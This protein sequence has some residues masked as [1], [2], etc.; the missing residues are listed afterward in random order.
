MTDKKR[1]R[2]GW[3]EGW[4]VLELKLSILMTSVFLVYG[5]RS[6]T[7][8]NG[9]TDIYGEKGALGEDFRESKEE[10]VGVFHSSEIRSEEF[11]LGVERLSMCIGSSVVEEG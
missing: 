3:V 5:Y 9:S 1:K 4:E 6:R 8:R 7:V 2:F 10:E 11:D